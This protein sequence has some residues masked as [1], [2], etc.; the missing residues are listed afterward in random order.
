M[1]TEHQTRDFAAYASN[2]ETWLIAARRH[3]AVAEVLMN[4]AEALRKKANRSLDEFSGCHHAAYFHGGLAIENAV[5][6][7]L[8]SKDPKIVS[9]GSVKLKKSWG[10][11]GHALLNPVRDLLGKL[12]K[13]E[14]QLLLRLKLEEHLVWAGKYTV[15]LK[16]AVLYNEAIMNV[17]RTSSMDEW[18]LLKSVLDRLFSQVARA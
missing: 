1:L 3:L 7:V 11:G 16:A 12:S 18:G 8:I 15:P 2:P 9:N 13:R 10:K 14:Y 6:A 5:K 17:M 4:R